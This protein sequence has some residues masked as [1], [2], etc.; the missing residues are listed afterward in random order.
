MKWFNHIGVLLMILV[1]SAGCYAGDTV[2]QAWWMTVD[3][4]PR[5]VRLN[6][7]PVSEVNSS[8]QY[9]RFLENNNIKNKIS[10]ENYEQ[11]L[12]SPFSFSKNYDLNENG[13][14]ETFRVGVYKDMDNNEGI[15]L[16]IIENDHLV[17][18]LSDSTS[19]NFSALL[20]KD[21]QLYWYRCMECGHF[22]K[23]VY[24]GSSYYLE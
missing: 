3:M 11:Y 10:N 24:S 15:F 7:Q 2:K 22:E 9:A 6:G 23:L 16:A 19:K 20:L 4:E 21:C 5:A 18:V 13:V 8:W 1:S 12:Q 17:K 14:V